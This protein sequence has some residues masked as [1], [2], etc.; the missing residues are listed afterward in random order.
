MCFASRR[1]QVARKDIDFGLKTTWLTMQGVPFSASSL[2]T[3]AGGRH[4]AK[5]TAID[6]D[7]GRRVILFQ[8]TEQ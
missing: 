3:R 6:L 5:L 4:A 2:P 7:S 8:V 1:D